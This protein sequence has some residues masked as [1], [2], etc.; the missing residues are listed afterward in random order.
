MSDSSGD[1]TAE[2]SVNSYFDVDE[3][4]GR[5]INRIQNRYEQRDEITGLPTCFTEFDKMTLGLQS[6]E[7]IVIGARPCMGKTT[8][9]VN[10]AVNIA[11]AKKA[12]VAIFCVNEDIEELGL[13]MISSIGGVSLQSLRNGRLEPFA[14]PRIVEAVSLLSETKIFII[15][16]EGFYPGDLRMRAQSIKQDHGL[17]LIVIDCLQSMQELDC[18]GRAG[19][20]SGILRSLKSL[21]Q[22]LSV[23]VV[24]LS[25]VSQEVELRE[26]KRPMISDLCDSREIERYADMVCFIYRDEYYNGEL[27]E[28]PDEAEIIIR[29]QRNGP[30]GRIKLGFVEEHCTFKNLE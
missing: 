2:I 22:D 9:A 10:I 27:S 15:E 28:C 8:F 20:V 30:T 26:D 18:G 12:P 13:R 4:I 21:A 16:K 24:V 14:W 25:Q 23:P 11:K 3:C 5:T 1:N 17:S 29:M 19:D 7:L 6:K